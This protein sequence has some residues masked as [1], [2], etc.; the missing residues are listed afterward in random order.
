M[1][2]KKKKVHSNR[3]TA[4]QTGAEPCLLPSWPIQGTLTRLIENVIKAYSVPIGSSRCFTQSWA[5]SRLCQHPES[6]QLMAT[7]ADP[8][9]IPEAART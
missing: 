2:T 1:R 3:S 5:E 9:T 8:S 6:L 4:D 7:V